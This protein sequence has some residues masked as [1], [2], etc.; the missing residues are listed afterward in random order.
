MS[1]EDYLN[2]TTYIEV[3]RSLLLSLVDTEDCW[4]DH[5]G[6]CQAHMYLD[7]RPGE[8]CPQQELKNILEAE[9]ARY[10]QEHKDDPEEWGDPVAAQ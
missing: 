4:F 3:S 9:D 6:G 2:R 5:H 8:L 10:Y 7:L 1:V